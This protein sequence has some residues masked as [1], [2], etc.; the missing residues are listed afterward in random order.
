MRNNSGNIINKPIS[1]A[2]KT[3][4]SGSKFNGRC[5][6]TFEEMD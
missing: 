2:K 6:T 4:M 5:T 3:E 1:I